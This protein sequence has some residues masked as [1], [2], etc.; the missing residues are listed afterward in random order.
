MARVFLDTNYFIDAIHRKP[1]K[2]IIDSLIDN[3]LYISTLSFHI[4]CYTFKIKLPNKKILAQ[5][6]KFQ[7]VDFSEAILAKALAGPTG[8]FED[9]VQLHSSA[10]SECNFFLTGDA[11][12]LN[13]KFFGKSQ[14]LPELARSNG[15]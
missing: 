12:L 5:K 1:E 13:V 9:N 6:E 3:I 11:K 14:I 8:D 10:E 4:Y 7:F 15:R 2:Q